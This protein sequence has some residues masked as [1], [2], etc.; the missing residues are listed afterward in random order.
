M[1]YNPSSSAPRG[2]YLRRPLHH[3][4]PGALVLAHLPPVIATFAE[5]RGYLPRS[6]P[7]LKHV[8]A[9]APQCVC[10]RNGM[11]RIDGRAVARTRMHDGAGRPLAAWP[12]CRRLQPGEVFLLAAGNTASFDGR[13]EEDTPELRPLKRTP[14]AVF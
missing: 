13:S 2:W 5:G 11:V 9:V 4:R 12:G 1:F 8:G 3:L 10:V 6:V 14:S 7:L